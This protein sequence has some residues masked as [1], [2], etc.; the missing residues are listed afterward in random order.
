[1][2]PQTREYEQPERSRPAP[3]DRLAEYERL[4]RE[5]KL[6]ERDQS[7]LALEKRMDLKTRIE[8]FTHEETHPNCVWLEIDMPTPA[9]GGAYSINDTKYV[10]VVRV[11]TCIASELLSM[12]SKNAEVERERM[13]EGGRIVNLGDITARVRRVG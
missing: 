3:S 8:R 1:M 12:I 9:Q 10:G 5:Y 4:N 13:R 2:R 11:P 7:P 6:W